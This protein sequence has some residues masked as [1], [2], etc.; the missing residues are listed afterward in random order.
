MFSIFFYA[1]SLTN[2]ET[3]PV[4]GKAKIGMSMIN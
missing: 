1:N 3:M 4:I 2:V